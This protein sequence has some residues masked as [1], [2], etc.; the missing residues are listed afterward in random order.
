[1]FM[2]EVEI[3]RISDV[4]YVLKT[5]VNNSLKGG[6]GGGGGVQP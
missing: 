2:I 6:G 3:L 4:I 1:M 5:G